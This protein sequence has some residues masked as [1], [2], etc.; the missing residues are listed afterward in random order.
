MLR[1]PTLKTCEKDG[2]SVHGRSTSSSFA[3]AAGVG[4]WSGKCECTAGHHRDFNRST[5]ASCA[6]ELGEVVARAGTIFVF[7][8][9][10]GFHLDAVTRGGGRHV[11]AVAHFYGVEEVLVEVVHVL[12]EAIV[13]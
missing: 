12:D 8:A 9:G 13:E 10:L 1:W 5:V 2:G 11:V 7:G 4:R 3:A 6:G